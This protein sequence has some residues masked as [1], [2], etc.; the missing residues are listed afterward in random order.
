MKSSQSLISLLAVILLLGI[1]GVIIYKVTQEPAQTPTPTPTV[2]ATV[3]PTAVLTETPTA[4]PTPTVTATPT[5]S[6]TIAWVNK[7][8]K[9]K[10]YDNNF[11]L[12][13]TV[14]VPSDVQLIQT[15][16]GSWNG[17]VL[18][19]G[20]KNFMAFNLPYELY[21]V[22]GYSSSTAVTSGIKNLKRV[23]S[24]K[25]FANSGNYKFAVAYVTSTLSGKDCTESMMSDPTTSPCAYP[26]LTYST[27]IW[28]SAYCSV[29][30]TYLAICDRIM[31]TIKVT[32]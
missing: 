20:T 21:E 19:K 13:V 17:I 5:P 1:G 29:D 25:V 3:T 31:K 4:S 12:T 10:E 26:A 23:R 30:S 7:T 16:V 15:T 28:F 8:G 32:K 27:D 2:T 11:T 24:K 9:I 14:S 6:P 22:Q 18:K